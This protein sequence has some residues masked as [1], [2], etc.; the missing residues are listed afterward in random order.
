MRILLFFASALLL[1]SCSDDFFSQTVEVDQPEYEKQLIVHQLVSQSDSVVGI[2]LTRNFGILETVP[3]SA[4]NVAG[5][6]VAYYVDGN[7]ALTLQPGP[8]QSGEAHLYK[9]AVPDGF[10]QPGSTYELRIGH[11]DYPA[12]LSRQTMPG[13]FT[14]DSVRFRENAGVD[15]F[16]DDLAA[17]D[18]YLQDQGG[19][20]NFYEVS[21]FYSYPEVVL[22]FDDQGNFIGYD[23]LPGPG[24]LNT[25]YPEDPEDP[26]LSFGAFNTMVV[27]DD[28]F[29][30]QAYKLRFR[31]YGQGGQG[32]SFKVRVRNVTRDY[33]TYSRSAYRLAESEDV[34][35]PL[36]EPVQVHDNIEGGIGIFGLSWER[37]FDVPQ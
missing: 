21:V 33:Y 36:V 13:P 29:D 18:V 23:T 7:P 30:G 32:S 34:G 14:V 2:N 35:L 10:W 3:D 31:F 22:I 6:E 28:F 9:A 11:P 20:E 25:V 17:I 12:L 5:A 8:A 24:Y 26:K 1:A 16:G 15:E 4:W 27:G 37:V 19:V